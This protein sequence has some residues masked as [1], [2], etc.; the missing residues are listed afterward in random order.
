MNLG[1]KIPKYTKS[2]TEEGS[3]QH[4]HSR[5]RFMPDEVKRTEQQ[6]RRFSILQEM[7]E[8]IMFIKRK[9]QLGNKNQQKGAIAKQLKNN[10]I[11]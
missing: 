8:H 1:T 2:N 6:E 3:Q 10:I 5:D 11:Q 4:Q 9:Q 7:T